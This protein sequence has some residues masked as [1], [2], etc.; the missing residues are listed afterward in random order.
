MRMAFFRCNFFLLIQFYKNVAGITR[1]PR[2]KPEIFLQ[3]W[4]R[5]SARSVHY[6]DRFQIFSII[7]VL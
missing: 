2:E 3:G 6:I 5:S 1:T 4:N 7:A